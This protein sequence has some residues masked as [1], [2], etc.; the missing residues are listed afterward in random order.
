[1]G[2]KTSQ[3]ISVSLPV[4]TVEH[5][6]AVAGVFGISRSALLATIISGPL[7]QLLDALA[8]DFTQND[9]EVTTYRLRGSSVDRIEKM[10]ADAQAELEVMRND[11]NM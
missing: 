9:P 6:G 3:K 8:D 7:V 5:L 1:M 11:P 2:I 10:I 4:E